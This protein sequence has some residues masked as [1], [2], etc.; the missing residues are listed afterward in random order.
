MM[1]PCKTASEVE[2]EPVQGCFMMSPCKTASEVEKEPVQGRLM[3]SSCET[4][5]EV[6]KEPVQGRLLMSPCKASSERKGTGVGL[7]ED[8]QVDNCPVW[9]QILTHD[10]SFTEFSWL[11]TSVDLKL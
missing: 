11:V 6:E 10:Q 9:F 7:P 4:T 3:M 8:D 5:S 2:K 1:S